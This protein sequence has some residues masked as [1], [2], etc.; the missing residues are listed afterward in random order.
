[1]PPFA[2]LGTSRF[3]RFDKISAMRFFLRSK[4]HNA[5][6]TEARIDYVGSITVDADLLR[7]AKMDPYE[8]VLVVNNTTGARVE[9]YLIRGPKGSGQICANGA[10]SHHLKKGDQVILMTFEGASKA[11]RPTIVLVDGRN[12][13][14]RLLKEKAGLRLP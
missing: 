11:P 7:R 12:R 8:R 13:F 2:S 6:V 4:I 14:V 5:T 9:T 3:W 10:A 1:M